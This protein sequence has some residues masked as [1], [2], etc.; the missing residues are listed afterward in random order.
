MF[1]AKVLK[2]RVGWGRHGMNVAPLPF[3]SPRDFPRDI[4]FGNPKQCILVYF[5]QKGK[6]F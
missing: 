2:V 4:S 3:V 5:E 6:E 1:L